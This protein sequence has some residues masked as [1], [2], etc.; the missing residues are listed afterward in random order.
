VLED[1]D[2]TLE[3]AV[4]EVELEVDP[5]ALKPANLIPAGACL[6]LTTLTVSV[7]ERFKLRF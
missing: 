3:R 2:I 6:P 7:D 4:L 1:L 5:L